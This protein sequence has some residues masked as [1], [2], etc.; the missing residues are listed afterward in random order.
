MPR[1]DLYGYTVET[2]F[3]LAARPARDGRAPD[4]VARSGSAGPIPDGPPAGTVL[5]HA[6]I[7]ANA[8]DVVR[9]SA[10]YTVRFA[11]VCDAHI[12]ARLARVDLRPASDDAR[13][14]GHILFAGNVMAVV[15]TLAGDC[16]LHA[17]AV[18][19]D[20]RAIAFVGFPGAGKSTI[21]ALACSAGAR[22]VTDDVLRVMPD[23]GDLLCAPGTTEVRLRPAAAS[24]AGDVHGSV[25]T[26]L[27]GRTAVAV[28]D[29][30][31]AARLRAIVF[32]KPLR[33]APEMS[34][35]ELS[36]A[37]ALVEL[38]R[39]PRTLGWTDPDVLE[40]AFRCNARVARAVPA[41]EALIPWGPPFDPVTAPRLLSILR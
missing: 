32:P 35:S 12:D 41:F 14:L 22:L 27:D 38:T 18:E 37:D 21:A 26:T 20:N 15:M 11:G 2:D 8:Y 10:G 17:S 19:I 25:A 40:R 6:E 5:A 30:G 3:A 4:V 31:G 7:G 23:D 28:H 24:L 13:G 16:V 29:P 1:Y 34:L 33:G 9:T 39:Y 36:P